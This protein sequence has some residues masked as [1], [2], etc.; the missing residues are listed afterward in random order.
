MRFDFGEERIGDILKKVPLVEKGVYLDLRLR[1]FSNCL[2]HSMGEDTLWSVI[3]KCYFDEE[4]KEKEE[5]QWVFTPSA[6][7]TK[8]EFT[9][10]NENPVRQ[11]I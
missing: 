9:A 5:C 11:I 1:P 7:R 10:S 2:R 6:F 4:I 8:L 3:Y